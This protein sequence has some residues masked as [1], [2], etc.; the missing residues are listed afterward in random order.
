MKTRYNNLRS[1]AWRMPNGKQKLAI[2]EEMIRIADA[3]LTEQDAYDS[4]MEY[5]D[6][7]IECGCPERLFI[8]FAWCLAKFEK[9]PSDYSSTTIMWHYKW[10][11]NHVWRIPQFSLEQ[12]E[13]LFADFKEKCLQYGFSLRAYYQQR[14]NFYLSQGD[15][16]EASLQYKQWREAPRDRISDCQ[17]CEQN[18]FG[19]YHFRINHYK[20]GMHVLK[21][22]LEGKLSCRTIPQNTYSQIIHPLLKL[23]EF[24]QAILTAN[25]AYRAIEGPS[26]LK[27]YGIFIEFF[28]VVNMGK[29]VQLYERTI[30]LGLDCKVAW[31]RMQYL[32]S[33]RLFLQQWSQ[34]KRRKKLVESATVTLDWLDAEIHRLEQAFQARNRNE[35]VKQFITEKELQFR[36]L[37]AKYNKA[38]T[39]K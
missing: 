9:N 27:E 7:A 39:D 11:L 30:R 4:R 35:Y 14:V 23:G 20:R 28:T 29:A 32:V 31:D 38:R 25:K 22:I 1:E 12:I 16:K 34:T 24:D 5:T 33:V 18:L 8:S 3:Y 26:Y 17:A 36:K 6:A 19:V 10:V 21:P 15:L 37:I 2:K 13:L